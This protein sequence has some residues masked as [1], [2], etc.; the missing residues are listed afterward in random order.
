V[1]REITPVAV[2]KD[3]PEEGIECAGASGE[4]DEE[5]CAV[6]ADSNVF[7]VGLA[8][9]EGAVVGFGDERP[10]VVIVDGED[11]PE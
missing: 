1:L 4:G 9:G 10:A 6:G 8:D 5:V 2:L 3:A 7:V 11:A